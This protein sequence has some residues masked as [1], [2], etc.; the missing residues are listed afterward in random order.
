MRYILLAVFVIGLGGTSVSAQSEIGVLNDVLNRLQGE[1]PFFE[2]EPLAFVDITE[3]CNDDR[4]VCDSGNVVELHLHTEFLFGY[5]PAEIKDLTAL[6]KVDVR[7]NFL[8]EDRSS[9]SDVELLTAFN[10]I[11]DVLSFENYAAH[12][13]EV[14][15]DSDIDARDGDL[16]KR[17]EEMPRFPGCE[18]VVTDDERRKCSEQEMLNFIYQNLFYPP[19][20]HAEKLEGMTMLQFIVSTNGLLGDV[21][22][23]KDLKDGY[24]CG[25]AARTTVLKMNYMTD[26]WI[27]GKQRGKPVKVRYTLPVRFA[28]M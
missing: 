14:G 26:R 21:K 18:E 27:C 23:I 9:S 8:S 12:L 15:A 11:D 1:N 16:F 10:M 6:R 28:A 24:K 25:A 13:E 3:A 22:I 20:A 4:V 17:V 7:N 5:I 2:V 19:G